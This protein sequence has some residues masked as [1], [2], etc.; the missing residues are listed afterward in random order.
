MERY[1]KAWSWLEWPSICQ[2][3]SPTKPIVGSIDWM[4]L[5]FSLKYSH[6]HCPLF[7]FCPHKPICLFLL[8]F[9]FF[10]SLLFFFSFFLLIFLLA[11]LSLLFLVIF[12]FF[13]L[14]LLPFLFLAI[15]IKKFLAPPPLLF[16]IIFS[17]LLPYSSSSFVFCF[18]FFSFSLLIFLFAP[19]SILFLVIFSSLSLYSSSFFVS[20]Y[21]SYLSPCSSSSWLLFLFCF[22]HFVPSFTRNVVLALFSQVKKIKSF[23][24]ILYIYRWKVCFVNKWPK[25]RWLPRWGLYWAFSLFIHRWER[26]SN[27][28]GCWPIRNPTRIARLE[29]GVWNNK[30]A[31]NTKEAFSYKV[32]SKK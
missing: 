9:F 26:K 7:F 2:C 27:M 16:L 17:F 18:F 29:E 5:C 12:S 8:F 19:L 23:F 1:R 28:W 10:F 14:A 3:T 4:K 31:F 11:L 21:F 15:F 32:R 24:I 13:L 22:L 6:P 30:R 20:C 25:E